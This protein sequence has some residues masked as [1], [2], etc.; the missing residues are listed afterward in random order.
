MKVYS[1]MD[2]IVVL[3]WYSCFPITYC[4]KIRVGSMFPHQ[5]VRKAKYVR[6]MRHGLHVGEHH[7]GGSSH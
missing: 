5:Q 3:E 4:T 2:L 7:A 6:Y 1:K